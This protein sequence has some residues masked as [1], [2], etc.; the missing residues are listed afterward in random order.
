VFWTVPLP[1][2]AV[3]FNPFTG[4][5]DMHVQDL[6]LLDF[7]NIPNGLQEG[8][9][10]LGTV[11]FD[12]SWQRPVTRLV[13]V[14]DTMF[15]FA[16]TYAED[17]ANVTWS[18]V[19][20]T[21]GFHFQANQGDFGTT[22]ALGGSPFAEIGFER[23]GI[24]FQPSASGQQ[25][26][27]NGSLLRSLASSLAAPA[28]AGLTSPLGPQRA[29]ALAAQTALTQALDQVFTDLTGMASP[30]PHRNTR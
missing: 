5:V 19:N 15:G 3:R 22:T 26:P 17:H 13:Q 21:T 29:E 4:T 10:D 12:V 14:R 16:G 11:S 7:G 23:N 20:D 1:D 25:G 24:F 28:L 27:G 2:A 9:H 30:G 6:H 18:G 8:P